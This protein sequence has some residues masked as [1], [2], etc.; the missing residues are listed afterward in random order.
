MID[1]DALKDYFVDLS[2]EKDIG[3]GDVGR[4]ITV[5]IEHIIDTIEN[6]PTI[7]PK[8]GEWITHEDKCGVDEECSACNNRT[9]FKY[10]FCPHCGAD[11]RKES[12]R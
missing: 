4:M 5:K 2:K 6:A 10:D 11:M 7:E 1:A 3:F 8:R 9:M 12:E